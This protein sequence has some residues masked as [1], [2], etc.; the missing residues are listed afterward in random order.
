[1]TDLVLRNTAEA[2]P[3]A[4]DSQCW[5]WPESK[6]NGYGVINANGETQRAHR[7][8]YE[9]ARG[10]IPEG[11]VL[12]HMCRNRACV[13]PWHLEPVTFVENVMR[14]LGAPA[15]N[16]R[17]TH[18]DKGHAFTPENTH[19]YQNRRVCKICSRE[20]TRVRMRALRARKSALVSGEDKNG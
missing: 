3:I 5:E 20:R 14:G 13:N 16:A 10:P 17:K 19:E 2:V 6:V 9:A 4:P 7:A 11:M 15:A 8:V 18:C 1:M 12:D